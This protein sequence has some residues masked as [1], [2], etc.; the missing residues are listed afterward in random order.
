MEREIGVDMDEIVQMEPQVRLVEVQV[1]IMKV[2]PH[3]DLGVVL[4]LVVMVVV[5]HQLEELQ[6]IIILH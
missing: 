2:A 4:V 5:R 6:I 1:H 3:P